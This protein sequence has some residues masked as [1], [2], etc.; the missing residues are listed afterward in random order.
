[1]RSLRTAKA[2]NWEEVA[3]GSFKF[4]ATPKFGKWLERHG[5]A[6]SGETP[7]ETTECR[8]CELSWKL[9]GIQAAEQN[10]ANSTIYKSFKLDYDVYIGK[11][12]ESTPSNYRGSVDDVSCMDVA[13]ILQPATSRLKILEL[14]ADNSVP[15]FEYPIETLGNLSY[16]EDGDDEEVGGYNKE[17]DRWC[18]A[19]PVG[20][21]QFHT[22][23]FECGKSTTGISSNDDVRAILGDRKGQEGQ[24]REC[25]VAWE[26]RMRYEGEKE[27]FLLEYSIETDPMSS[28]DD[29]IHL[30]GS[31]RNGMIVCGD[32]ADKILAGHHRRILE[33]LLGR[34][35]IVPEI[36][37]GEPKG[38]SWENRLNWDD[39]TWNP[40]S[41]GMSEYSLTPKSP[42]D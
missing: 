11:G 42:L 3:S 26:L 18:E 1:M 16:G 17:M 15:S 36:I 8:A 4:E 6:P 9:R 20:N 13:I 34:H 2:G 31:G 40:D 30:D 5:V 14:I 25:N 27:I 38:K 19:H 37:L 39:F 32:I 7:P 35:H 24:G 22:R 33:P 21:G 10:D 41:G 28:T 12:R 29:L 23:M